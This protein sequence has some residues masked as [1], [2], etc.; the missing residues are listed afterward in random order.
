VYRRPFARG[1]SGGGGRKGSKVFEASPSERACTSP[2][3]SK[4]RV[5]RGLTS[6][7]PPPKKKRKKG[8]I[9][10]F[11]EGGIA[12]RAI[13]GSRS[14]RGKIRTLTRRKGGGEERSLT[15]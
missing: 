12:A 7:T 1:K 10:K 3:P 15:Y 13:L 2:I 4:K 6:W 8:L 5:G 11:N 14:L 9:P